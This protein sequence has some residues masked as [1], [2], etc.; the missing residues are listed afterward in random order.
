MRRAAW[1]AMVY[2][3]ARD[4]ERHNKAE[5]AVFA[6]ALRQLSPNERIA[7]MDRKRALG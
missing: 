3:L 6:Q 4:V 2:E 1:I 5:H 7:I